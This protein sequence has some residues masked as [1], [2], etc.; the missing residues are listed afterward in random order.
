MNITIDIEGLKEFDEALKQFTDKVAKKSIDSALSAMATPIIKEAK[1]L[2]SVADEAHMMLYGKA[3]R[4]Q[5]FTYMPS[6]G[7]RQ[8]YNR[9]VTV[10]PGLLKEGIRR[11]KLKKRELSQL[12]VSAGVAIYIGKGTKQKIYPRY[13][14]F[15][16]FGTSKHAAVPFLRPAFDRQYQTALNRFYT[17]LE[18]NIAKNQPVTDNEPTE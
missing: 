13:W 5:S 4:T 15:I 2:A 10:Q 18:Q 6:L 1:L 11:R 16:E 7:R 14:H 9:Y 17:K 8:K 12:G 3:Y